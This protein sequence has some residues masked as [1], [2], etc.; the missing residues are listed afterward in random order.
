MESSSNGRQLP[1]KL[2]PLQRMTTMQLEKLTKQTSVESTNGLIA[3]ANCADTSE[4]AGFAQWL[5][6]YVAWFSER[7]VDVLN[8]DVCMEYALL[9]DLDA[10]IPL[11]KELLR[12]W[13]ISF[14]NKIKSSSF[15]TGPVIT[16]FSSSLSAV[17][18]SILEETIDPLLRI[19]NHFI[20][21]INPE[22]A[23]MTAQTYETH[24]IQ[25]NAAFRVLTTIQDSVPPQFDST[26]DGGPYQRL[27]KLLNQVIEVQK[28]F[29]YLY[30]AE[31]VKHCLS[32]MELKPKGAHKIARDRKKIK[33]AFCG[34]FRILAAFKKLADIEFDFASFRDGMQELADAV[35]REG[36]ERIHWCSL[37]GKI[38]YGCVFVCKDPSLKDGLFDAIDSLIEENSTDSNAVC[39]RFGIADELILLINNLF[40]RDVQLAALQRLLA[41]GQKCHTMKNSEG[42][43]LT[44]NAIMRLLKRV[45]LIQGLFDFLSDESE[46]LGGSKESD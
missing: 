8:K 3:A 5:S 41:I 46:Q 15:G 11:Y 10:E 36:S 26:I 44:L 19:A 38:S 13:L 23:V 28:Y 16:A 39:I 24:N 2:P 43:V 7:P 6:E 9:A 35:R 34:A 4:Q 40:D 42:D 1:Q 31:M 22:D 37:I 30:Q 25:L 12:S 32:L 27:K 33:L 18:A 17:P 14:C 29:P 45:R 21:G 20:S